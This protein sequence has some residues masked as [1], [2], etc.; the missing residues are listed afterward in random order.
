LNVITANEQIQFRDR[1][2]E[3]TC[4]F[5]IEREIRAKAAVSLPL[6]SSTAARVSALFQH[7]QILTT[8]SLGTAGL[9]PVKTLG[10]F[11]GLCSGG[12]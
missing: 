11:F 10:I 3:K 5:P 7:R 12:L 2:M 6:R 9:T 4:N 1:A 8:L